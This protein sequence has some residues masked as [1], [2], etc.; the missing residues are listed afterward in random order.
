MKIISIA[1]LVAA[2]VVL[3]ASAAP[4]TSESYGLCVEVADLA[5]AIKARKDRGTSKREV[6]ATHMKL[7]KN[8]AAQEL[9]NLIADAVFD[10]VTPDELFSECIKARRQKGD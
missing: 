6:Y 4:L 9:A 3:P 7:G 2:L 10:G 1:A 8:Q 5:D